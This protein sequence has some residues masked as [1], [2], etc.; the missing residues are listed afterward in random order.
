MTTLKV[1]MRRVDLA[2]FKLIAKVMG[3]K[4]I[5]TIVAAARAVMAV[6]ETVAVFDVVACSSAPVAHL[7]VV[8]APCMNGSIA[9]SDLSLAA[10]L[11]FEVGGCMHFAVDMTVN[12]SYRVSSSKAVRTP[13]HGQAFV[14][15]GLH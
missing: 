4:T 2:I 12:A 9:H 5:C 14:L 3:A 13:V 8:L 7:A 11:A 10:S 15:E 1:G 6:S